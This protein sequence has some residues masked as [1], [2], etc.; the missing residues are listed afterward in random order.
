MQMQT[1]L[2]DSPKQK[3]IS[4]LHAGHAD[5]S[6]TYGEL[7]PNLDLLNLEEAQCYFLFYPQIDIRTWLSFLLGEI[8]EVMAV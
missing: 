4:T 8:A 6:E 1:S 2:N 3:A 7:P 5:T